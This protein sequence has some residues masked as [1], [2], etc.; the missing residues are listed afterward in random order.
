M[1]KKGLGSR[2]SGSTK[3]IVKQAAQQAVGEPF[4][5]LKTAGKQVS[6]IEAGAKPTRQMPQSESAA[7]TEQ[8][9]LNEEKINAKS[10]RLLGALE[11]EMEDIRKQKEHDK[12]IKIKEEE[13]QEQAIEE[14]KTSKSIPEVSGKRA[15][16][17][18]RGMKG[19][20]KK[21]KTKAEI[22]MPPSG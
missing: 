12:A 11:N 9:S 4:E 20:L 14:E 6:G 7:K 5:I 21:L 17:A 13:V 16:G 19:K 2:V 1:I 18:V 15:R 22:R 3:K 10:K 8:P